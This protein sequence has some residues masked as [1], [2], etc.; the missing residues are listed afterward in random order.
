MFGYVTNG[1]I[2][3]IIKGNYADVILTYTD[4]SGEH[5][6]AGSEAIPTGSCEQTKVK[7]IYDMAGNAKDWTIEAFAR[8][9]CRR[10]RGGVYNDTDDIYKNA[11]SRKGTSPWAIEDERCTRTILYIK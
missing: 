8:S 6:K 10:W 2:D 1:T 9:T 3:G 5:T 4:S 11:S 7:N